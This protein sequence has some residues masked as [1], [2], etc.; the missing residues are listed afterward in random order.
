MRDRK[1]LVIEDNDEVREFIK[2]CLEGEYAIMEARDG[3]EGWQTAAEHLPDLI[4]SD[5]MMPEMDGN[6]FCKLVRQDERTSHI[7]VIMLTAKVALEQ[8]LEGLESGADIYLTKPYNIQLLKSYISN[9]LRSK[10]TLRQRYSQKIFL[11]PTMVEIGTV[12]KKFME[13][14]MNIIE[15][16]LHDTDFHVAVLAEKIGMS[17]AVLYKKFYA[18]AQ[19]PIGE[20]IKTIRLKKAAILLTNDKF[21]ISEVAWEVGFSD[22]KYFSKEFKRFFGKSPS[23]YI[24]SNN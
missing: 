17:K 23:E 5:I 3:K 24:A 22:R 6:E 4:I 21:N 2:M 10:E 14:L 9:L 20:F 1:I 11:E 19:T 15:A 8:Q 12:D 7:P 16:N 18:L 13:K